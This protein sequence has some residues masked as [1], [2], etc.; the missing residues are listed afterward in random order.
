MFEISVPRS[1]VG[2]EDGLVD[3]ERYVVDTGFPPMKKCE[4]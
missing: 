4:L 3:E 2:E 1:Q